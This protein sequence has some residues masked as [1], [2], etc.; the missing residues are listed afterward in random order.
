MSVTIKPLPP[1]PEITWEWFNGK[2][3]KIVDMTDHEILVIWTYLNDTRVKSRFN[4]SMREFFK[5][6]LQYRREQAFWNGADK[7][8]REVEEDKWV[9]ED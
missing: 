8:L 6:E 1:R 4:M 5:G 3:E 7:I 9:L 2:S